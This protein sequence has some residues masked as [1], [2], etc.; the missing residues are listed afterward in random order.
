[1][2]GIDFVASDYA[3]LKI[4]RTCPEQTKTFSGNL[5]LYYFDEFGDLR[6]E[7][8]V[9]GID[10]QHD[11]WRSTGAGAGYLDLY[12]D[13]IWLTSGRLL[14][15]HRGRLIG[16]TQSDGV[17]IYDPNMLP[18]ATGLYMIAQGV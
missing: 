13:C 12:S 18:V 9:Y 11:G 15:V 8:A 7:P 1:M 5:N 17:N 10:G 4:P 2:S 6:I 3:K 16:H 14:L